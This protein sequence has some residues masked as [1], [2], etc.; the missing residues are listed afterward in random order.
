M[1]ISVFGLG[2]V[3]AVSGACLADMGHYV[4][5]VDVDSFKVGAINQGQSPIVE[6]LIAELM[7]SAVAAGR[8]RATTEVGEAV[9]ATELSLV[10]VGTPSTTGGGLDTA[11]VQRVSEQIGEALKSKAEYHVV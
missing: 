5:G 1:R 8:L 11:Y 7:Q 10:C 6:E 4:V 9:A 3:G 2:Y